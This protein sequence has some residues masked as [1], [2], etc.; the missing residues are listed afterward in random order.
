[1]VKKYDVY[2]VL[3]IIDVGSDMFSLPIKAES[4]VPTV[5]IEPEG[6]LIFEDVFLRNPAYQSI[7]LVNESSLKARF[8]I[9]P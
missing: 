6:E 3:D 5:R 8:N 7:T 4:E 1:M 9:V 2:M